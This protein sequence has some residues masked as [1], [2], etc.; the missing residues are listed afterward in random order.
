MTKY[1]TLIS[2]TFLLI[3]QLAEAQVTP[4]QLQKLD[5]IYQKAL[6]DWNVPGMGVAIVSRD[7]VWL[8]KGYGFTDISSRNPVDNNTL[9]ALASNTKAFTATSLAMLVDRGQLNWSD[10]VIDHLPWFALYDPYVTSQMTVED[11]LC[12]RS[13]LAT[14][15]GDLIWYASTYSREEVIRRARYLKPVYG[16]RTQFGYSNIM[17]ITAGELIPAIT[18]TSWDDFVQHEI[19][20]AIG[21]RRSLLH[22]SDLPKRD[23]IAQPHT[24][25][26]G[27][28]LQIPWLDWNNMAPA[29]SLISSADDMA[30]W[31]QFNL[32]DGI[33]ETDTLVSDGQMFTLQ[34]P[35][36]IL[37]VSKGS[38]KIFPSTH[39]KSYALGWSLMDYLGQKVVSHNGGYD[40]MISQTVFIPEANVGFVIMTNALSSLYYPLMYH[41]LDVLLNNPEQ[42]N[43]NEMIH[44]RIEEGEARSK[45]VKEEME[46]NRL[47]NTK[48]SLALNE[49]AGFYGGK[50][51]DSIQVSMS[52]DGMELQFMRSPLFHGKLKHWQY[53]T[54]E[55]TFEALP[56]LPKGFVTFCLNRDGKVE[57]ME[58]FVDNPD[59]DFTEFDLL[60]LPAEN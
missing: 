8:S 52:K 21:M 54:F 24:Y 18:G 60:K 53:D 39:F 34:S 48:P 4:A 15:S 14:F 59:F 11:L 6:N 29:G 55:V 10:K 20:D 40:G 31:L 9:F 37:N 1:F 41:T 26:D 32:N 45:K 44:Q 23:N 17:F 2:I 25:V 3:F 5:S 13:G 38:T 57:K 46:K 50:V 28:L 30:K 56:S 36:T 12:H 22:V 58:I 7:T 49:Y 47:K 43:W 27:K 33:H 16:F 35:H 19:L 51:Y 42:K